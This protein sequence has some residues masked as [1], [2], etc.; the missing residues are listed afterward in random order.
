MRRVPIFDQGTLGSCTGNAAAGWLATDNSVRPGILDGAQFGPVDEDLAVKIYSAAT[1]IDPFE[2]S[3]P[4]KD[5]GSDGLSVVKILKGWGL[6]ES[7]SHCFSLNDVL[8]ALQNGPVLIGTNWYEGMFDPDPIGLVAISGA[9]Q[10]GHEYLAVA[11]DVETE[12]V[13]FANSWG[14]GWAK[15]GYF[16]QSYE[17]LSR[18]LAEQGDA[19]VPH[20]PLPSVPEEPLPFSFGSLLRAIARWLRE[21]LARRSAPNGGSLSGSR[22]T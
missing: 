6:V 12:R 8:R 7:Y 18:L 13:L 16:W 20:A 14:P 5:T 10:G 4:P 15:D 21:L 19:M 1:A 9:S 3:Y 11:V 22:P 2:G 17:T